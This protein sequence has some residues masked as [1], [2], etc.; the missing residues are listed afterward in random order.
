MIDAAYFRLC[1]TSCF[2]YQGIQAFRMDQIKVFFC[3][4][5]LN[6]STKVKHFRLDK[7]MGC[8]TCLNSSRNSRWDLLGGL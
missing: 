7:K 3:Y 5:A 4:C 2:K 6:K 8:K 1:Y